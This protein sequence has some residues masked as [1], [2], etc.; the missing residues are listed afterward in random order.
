MSE[1]NRN[2]IPRR[3]Q[4]PKPN[5]SDLQLMEASACCKP[6]WEVASR[7]DALIDTKSGPRPTLRSFDAML[8]E[9]AAWGSG[10]YRSLELSLA[11][12]EVWARLRSTVR[13]ASLGNP[14]TQL[15]EKPITREQH[16]KFRK[17]HLTD[18][19]IEMMHHGI[20]EA[21]IRAAQSMGMLVPGLGSSSAPDVRSF[22]AADG[23]WMHAERSRR[24][25]GLVV[26]V[27]ARSPH[28]RERVVISAR[29]ESVRSDE[30]PPD[31][32]TVA[33]DTILDLTGRYPKL[34]DGLRGAV[35][36][37][38][39][40][41]DSDRLLEAG[42]I[43]VTQVPRDDRRLSR[44]RELR[45]DCELLNWEMKRGLGRTPS[46]N[47][48]IEFRVIA[49]QAHVLVT[50]LIAYHHRTGADMTPWFGQHQLPTEGRLLE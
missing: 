12:R 47:L 5:L 42:I 23:C 8:F 18:Q 43:P 21:A 7:L 29:A 45:K 34:R 28:D 37:R 48:R 24:P 1:H 35:Y 11:D 17:H 20:D 22:V 15:A 32:A 3:G 49:F 30:P 25:V 31:D 19:F 50:A 33:V 44:E 38:M 9:V 14:R 27:V 4:A 39:P 10:S 6:L 40:D 41:S 2:S 36:D 26:P 16:Y 46:W 13:A